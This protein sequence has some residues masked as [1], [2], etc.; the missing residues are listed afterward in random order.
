MR[1]LI[2]ILFLAFV[3]LAHPDEAKTVN[4]PQFRGVGAS[5]I[6]EGFATPTTWDAPASRNLKWKTAIPGLGLSSPVIWGDKVFLT[7]A[8][9]DRKKDSLKIGLYHEIAPV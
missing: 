9:S 8:T 5:G 7:T 1:H 2:P 3:S 4:W 6:A